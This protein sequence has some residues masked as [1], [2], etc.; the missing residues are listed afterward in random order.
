MR[1][2]E[3]REQRQDSQGHLLRLIEPRLLAYD[4]RSSYN[5]TRLLSVAKRWR[6][7]RWGDR[8]GRGDQGIT[9]THQNI[10]LGGKIAHDFMK[11][12]WYQGE[13]GNK[14]EL[15]GLEGLEVDRM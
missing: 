4:S 12:K 14:G 3:K 5:P 9:N 11:K 15:E 7:R 13:R 2:E 1:F 10:Q 8:R 6:D